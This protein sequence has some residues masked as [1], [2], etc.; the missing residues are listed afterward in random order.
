MLSWQ[1]E[2]LVWDWMDRL[3]TVYRAGVFS[4]FFP[5]CGWLIPPGLTEYPC[6]GSISL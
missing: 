1:M 2:V 6:E 5:A 3:H 4:L